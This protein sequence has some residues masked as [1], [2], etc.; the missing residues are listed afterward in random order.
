MIKNGTKID[1]NKKKQQQKN[2]KK[3]KKYQLVTV[4]VSMTKDVYWQVLL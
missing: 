1:K 2:K 3:N 4:K